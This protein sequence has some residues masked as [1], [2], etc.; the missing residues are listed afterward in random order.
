[1][2]FELDS[3]GR[4]VILQY[5]SHDET[6]RNLDAT[7][8][9]KQELDKI[10][11]IIKKI[12]TASRSS[13]LPTEAQIDNDYD[14]SE[15]GTNITDYAKQ[16]KTSIA[17]AKVQPDISE[18]T[19]KLNESPAV[20]LNLD[21]S[22]EMIKLAEK[23]NE[24]A[25]KK[26]EIITE[27]EGLRQAKT[28]QIRQIKSLITSAQAVLEKSTATKEQT[29][30]ALTDLKTLTRAAG[31]SVEAQAKLVKFDLPLPPPFPINENWRSLVEEVQQTLRTEKQA[32]KTEIEND[33]C[34]A[35]SPQASV[36]QQVKALKNLGKIDGEEDLAEEKSQLE[37]VAEK[38]F[39]QDP[40]ECL[41]GFIGAIKESLKK[42]QLTEEELPSE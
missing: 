19:N 14:D 31:D 20:S 22:A 4:A 5:S 28:E 41:K 18:I 10:N 1:D 21:Y 6:D 33:L 32:H 9:D 26:A 23:D 39:T 13:D 40:L 42:N 17:Q 2:Q 24:R 29:Q 11:E 16:L 30:Q 12:K 7:K 27:I 35:Q 15:K 38:L 34:A 36:A 8:T 25:S 37:R 3:S